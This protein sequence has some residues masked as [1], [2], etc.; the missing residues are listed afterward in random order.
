[1][2]LGGDEAP[3]C[4]RDIDNLFHI[5]WQQNIMP[6]LVQADV[7]LL[8]SHEDPA[9]FVV[10]EALMLRL[11]VA[12]FHNSVSCHFGGLPVRL[13]GFPSALTAQ[14]WLQNVR[15]KVCFEGDL[16]HTPL[17][18]QSFMSST[19]LLPL[20]SKLTKRRSPVPEFSGN[21]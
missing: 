10:L 17:Q 11:Q 21:Y 18:L 8:T 9:P 7:F 13:P 5:P 4:F 14:S 2:W 3:E 19:A 12:V 6:F 1:M 16:S 20:L 15:R